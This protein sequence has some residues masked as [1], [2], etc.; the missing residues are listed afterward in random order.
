[1]E[2][3]FPSFGLF[4]ANSGSSKLLKEK[5]DPL[6]NDNDNVLRETELKYINLSETELLVLSACETAVSYSL[7]TGNY[8]LSEEFI[9]SGVKNV[10]STIWKVDDE[11][12]QKFMIIFYESLSKGITIDS[13]LK[14]AK[15]KIRENYPH[16]YYWAPFVLLSS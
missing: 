1:M 11:V 4:F 2:N 9:K 5:G 3:D 7:M 14:A 12:T 13:S 16:P 6:F 8:N 15:S 10:I